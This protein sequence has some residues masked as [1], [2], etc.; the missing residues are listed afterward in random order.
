MAYRIFWRLCAMLL[1]VICLEGYNKGVLKPDALRKLR[2]Q[3]VQG[4]NRVK[5]GLRL[6]GLTQVQAAAALNISQPHVSKIVRGKYEDLPL[7]TTR[8]LAELIGCPIEDLFP[9]LHEQ[10]A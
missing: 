6:A 5:F 3:P 8:G 9:A 2:R 4:K 10:V 7:E 1:T